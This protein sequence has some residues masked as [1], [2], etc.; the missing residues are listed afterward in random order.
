MPTGATRWLGD[1]GSRTRDLAWSFTRC[2]SRRRLPRREQLVLTWL[3]GW[4]L[5]QLAP[6]PPKSAIAL[7][8]AAQAM[9]AVDRRM[10]VELSA[11]GRSQSFKGV[12]G[13]PQR[14]GPG[15]AAQHRRQVAGQRHA[16]RRS[17]CAG[18]PT[19]GVK[20]QR[21][22]RRAALPGTTWTASPGVREP[23]RWATSSIAMVQVR[24]KVSMPDAP[25]VDR[26]PAG[27]EVENLNLSQ[28]VSAESL[29]VEGRNAA[30]SLQDRRIK[31]KE[32][33]DDRFVGGGFAG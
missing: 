12:V 8:R 32:F 31:H 28:G 6:T 23:S 2:W 21:P 26:I 20:P 19:A 11:A 24:S 3:P 4:C 13:S 1:Y 27:F 22:D 30:E 17:G 10:G 18:Y 9:G 7:L 33:R 29:T 25:V 16:V 5:R 14:A 15:S